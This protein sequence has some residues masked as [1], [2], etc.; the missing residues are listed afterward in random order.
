MR[1]DAPFR[2]SERGVDDGAGRRC[3]PEPTS[4]DAEPVEQPMREHA[5]HKRKREERS[6]HGEQAD[7]SGFSLATEKKRS[8]KK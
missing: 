8:K 1:E 2:V 6:G 7:D 4:R 5:R 3:A